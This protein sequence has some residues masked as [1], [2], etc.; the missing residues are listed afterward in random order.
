V[1]KNE[2]SRSGYR[3]YSLH[4]QHNANADLPNQIVTTLTTEAARTASA[5]AYLQHRL[6]D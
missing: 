5:R 6:H 3:R 1:T 2:R 4:P